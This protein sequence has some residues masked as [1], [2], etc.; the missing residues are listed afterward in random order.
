MF[1]LDI[2]ASDAFLEMPTSSRE[3]YFHL[4][5]YA[6]DDG[7][8]SPKK[9]MRMVGASDD[10]LKVLLGKRFLIS[11]PSGVVVVKHWKM[12]N[13]LQKDRYKKTVYT[14]EIKA[15][16]TKDNGSYT[17]C[18]QGVYAGKVRLGKKSKGKVI[19]QPTVDEKEALVD[20]DSKNIQAMFTIFYEI[21]PTINYGNKT[22]RSSASRIIKK[23]GVEKAL[24]SA[25]AAVAIHGKPYAPTIT[26]PYQ[27]E[28]KLSELVAF[29]KKQ[30]SGLI[31]TDPN[32]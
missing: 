3:L 25:R 9:I 24:G 27:L 28:T 23:L 2:V 7:F 32:L 4:G 30:S 10:D 26:N 16:I 29:Y 15:L 18:I 20:E 6:D 1:S 17:E 14:E 13:Y 31:I 12:N 8:V 21:N 11:F 5:M 22:Q 19:I